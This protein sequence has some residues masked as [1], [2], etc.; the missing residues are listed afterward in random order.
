MKMKLYNNFVIRIVFDQEDQAD[1]FKSKLDEKVDDLEII[2]KV[3]K[4]DGVTYYDMSLKCK[5][6][7][8]LVNGT[9]MRWDKSDDPNDE[10]TIN[11]FI[12]WLKDFPLA[13]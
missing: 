5:T 12:N 3:I 13:F 2:K 9:A 8:G 11:N 10:E 6:G 7:S 4:E 1:T